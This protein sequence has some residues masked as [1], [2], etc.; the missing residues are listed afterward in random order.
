MTNSEWTQKSFFSEKYH[1]L[2]KWTSST[3]GTN[4]LFNIPMVSTIPGTHSKIEDLDFAENGNVLANGG[5]HPK[6]AQENWA[7]LWEVKEVVVTEL[8]FKVVLNGR[9]IP[10]RRAS[11]GN[12]KFH[13]RLSALC[14]EFEK[15]DQL[16]WG[17]GWD[18][19]S[20]YRYPPNKC[21]VMGSRGGSR[22]WR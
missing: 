11:A 1:L 12:I 9:Q 5:A 4:Q 6:L 7:W 20:L 13:V 18:C 2:I 8:W 16:A 17:V 22:S 14:H 15:F 19:R 10:R 3:G 21:E